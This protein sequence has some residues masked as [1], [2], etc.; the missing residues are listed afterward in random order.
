MSHRQDGS[1]SPDE[2]PAPKKSNQ[3]QAIRAP[4]GGETKNAP[5]DPIRK[6]QRLSEI[7]SSKA[8]I[9]LASRPE[10]VEIAVREM[11]PD[12]L[13]VIGSWEVPEAV[14][15]GFRFPRFADMV[16]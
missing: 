14:V 11:R 6:P 13:A 5:I 12:A 7:F 3:R 4:D 16:V 15:E 2:A 1:G 9:L 8:L 10:S